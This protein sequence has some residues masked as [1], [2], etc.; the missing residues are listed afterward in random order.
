MVNRSE[1]LI[2]EIE[3][4]CSLKEISTERFLTDVK[5]MN[6][7]TFIRKYPELFDER[8]GGNGL[9]KHL[10]Q[11][12]EASTLEKKQDKSLES[13]K[14]QVRILTNQKKFSNN[15]LFRKKQEK[16]RR[17]YI[18][19][20]KVEPVREAR[21]SREGRK[22]KGKIE[23]T[24]FDYIKGNV[25]DIDTGRFERIITSRFKDAWNLKI[26]ALR[27]HPLQSV[28]LY[29]KVDILKSFIDKNGVEHEYLSEPNVE[30]QISSGTSNHE[31]LLELYFKALD[32]LDKRIQ[33]KNS[34]ILSFKRVDVKIFRTG[35]V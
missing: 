26:F 22:L 13:L 27:P 5:T 2:V 1:K 18:K 15:L 33:E 14:G 31:T 32:E 28:S 3:G 8:V 7:Q 24:L 34:V 10:G 11:R 25:N 6:A 9:I 30:F 12:A 19:K 17:V 35:S 16:Y 4:Y 20:Q 23:K 21:Q 29:C